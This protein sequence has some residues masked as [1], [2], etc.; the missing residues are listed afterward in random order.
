MD[1]T[2]LSQTLNVEPFEDLSSFILALSSSTLVFYNKGVVLN[3]S[4]LLIS[5]SYL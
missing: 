2:C 3:S 4:S 1:S 5:S